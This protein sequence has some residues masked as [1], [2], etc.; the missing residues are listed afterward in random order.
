[1]V[2]IAVLLY[3]NAYVFFFQDDD[4]SSSIVNTSVDTKA[5]EN[6]EKAADYTKSWPQNRQTHEKKHFD[7]E[8]L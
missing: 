4:K 3:R 8:K 1:M 7:V 2:L 5:I 6:S